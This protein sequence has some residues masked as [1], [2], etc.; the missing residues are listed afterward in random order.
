MEGIAMELGDL[1]DRLISSPEMLA[2][3]IGALVGGL[4]SGLAALGGSLF[5]EK[6]KRRKAVRI[7]MY[8]ELLPP[9][10][11]EASKYRKRI[12]EEERPEPH[13]GFGSSLHNSPADLE[14]ISVMAGRRERQLASRIRAGVREHAAQWAD[15]DNYEKTAHGGQKWVGDSDRVRALIEGIDDDA[16]A[17]EARLRKKVD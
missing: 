13:P 5:V 16:R 1:W 14:H 10:R 4:A 3:L 9:I 7:R 8:E 17:L 6:M 15:P 2:A 11:D 12:S